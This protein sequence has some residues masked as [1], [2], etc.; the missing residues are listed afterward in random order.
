MTYY[1]SHNYTTA[2]FCRT[3]F[4]LLTWGYKTVL[5]THQLKTR[6]CPKKYFGAVVYYDQHNNALLSLLQRNVC[7][8]VCCSMGSEYG[9]IT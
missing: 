4:V 7:C 2:F 3:I 1:A 6:M 8:S 5:R 9:Y